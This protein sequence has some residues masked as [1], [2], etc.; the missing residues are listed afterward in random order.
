M[1]L[2]DE[3]SAGLDSFGDAVAEG[4]EVLD[5]FRLELGAEVV[6]GIDGRMVGREVGLGRAGDDEAEHRVVDLPRSV[7]R[8]S[9][10]RDDVVGGPLVP[11]LELV[12]EAGDLRGLLPRLRPRTVRAV[13]T[14]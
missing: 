13:G 9:V 6:K 11:R 3:R 5:V 1:V 14:R 4:F 10:Q 7:V 2:V 12:C 8:I